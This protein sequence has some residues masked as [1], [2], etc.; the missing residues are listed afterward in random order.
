MSLCTDHTFG[1]LSALPISH[2]LHFEPAAMSSVTGKQF[3]ASEDSV[4]GS[5]SDL[6]LHLG[7]RSMRPRP[8]P[9]GGRTSIGVD[10]EGLTRQDLSQVGLGNH[11]RIYC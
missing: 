4:V 11:Y 10:P 3:H 2:S 1:S 5:A 6:L 9:V 7:S 8:D